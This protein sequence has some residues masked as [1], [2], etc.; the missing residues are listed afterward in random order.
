[1]P[2]SAVHNQ[3]YHCLK[4][5]AGTRQVAKSTIALLPA[6]QQTRVHQLVS[7]RPSASVLLTSIVLPFDAREDV[8]WVQWHDHW[9]MFF[10]TAL[11]KVN[12]NNWLDFDQLP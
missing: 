4:H 11:M 1:M 12:L 2:S 8:P 7:G 6:F 9:I 3:R 5:N 10:P